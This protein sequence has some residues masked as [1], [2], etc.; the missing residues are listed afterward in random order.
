MS[1]IRLR[2][3]KCK[4]FYDDKECWVICDGCYEDNKQQ[5]GEFLEDLKRLPDSKESFRLLE[6]WEAKKNGF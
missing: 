6:K 2:C 5:I 1:Q 3:D 4:E